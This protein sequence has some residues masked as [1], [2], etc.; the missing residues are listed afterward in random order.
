MPDSKAVELFGT[1]DI[2]F[3]YKN[4]F[5]GVR[6]SV[7]AGDLTNLAVSFKNSLSGTKK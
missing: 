7:P 1:T 6:G 4:Y 2:I 5:A 3:L